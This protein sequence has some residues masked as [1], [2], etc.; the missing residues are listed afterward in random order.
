MPVTDGLYAASKARQKMES[1]EWQ[2][3][4][5]ADGNITITGHNNGNVVGDVIIPAAIEGRPVTSVGRCSPRDGAFDDDLM[6]YNPIISDGGPISV[7]IPDGVRSIGNFAFAGCRG[8]TQVVIPDSVRKIGISAFSG[9]DG[10][11]SVAIPS[12]VTE[13]GEDAFMGCSGLMRVSIPDGIRNVGQ[14]A[15]DL[16]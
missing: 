16:Y 4:S 2:Y 14:G 1:L 15:F 9:C 11:T 5:G 7:V 8:L 13:I 10:L 3:E 12:G 6:G